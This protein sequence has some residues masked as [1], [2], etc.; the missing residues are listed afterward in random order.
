MLSILPMNQSNI[1][2]CLG[3]P[4]YNSKSQSGMILLC[5]WGTGWLHLE[6][7]VHYNL[8]QVTHRVVIIYIAPSKDTRRVITISILY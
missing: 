6:Q 4:V 5:H 7:S 1:K 3:G 8:S 2:S